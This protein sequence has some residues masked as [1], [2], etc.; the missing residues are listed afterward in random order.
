[1]QC[2]QTGQRPAD[3]VPTLG[4][5]QG[6][7]LPVG[8]RLGDVVGIEGKR[9]TVRMPR[10][11]PMHEMHLLDRRAQCLVLRQRRRDVDRPPLR[12]DATGR[13]PIEIG[14]E[15]RSGPLTS[16]LAEISIREPKRPG[17]V[18]VPVDDG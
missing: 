10:D 3:A 1:M 5:D 13:Q 12:A 16:R 7:D 6:C 18:V 4:S 9:K 14:V 15:L 11:H 17:Q 8:Q 2:P